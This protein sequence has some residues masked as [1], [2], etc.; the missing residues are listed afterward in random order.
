MAIDTN[1]IH[2]EEFIKENRVDGVTTSITIKLVAYDLDDLVEFTGD[3]TYLSHDDNT[4]EN[5]TI[6]GKIYWDFDASTALT[7]TSMNYTLP[8]DK[9]TTLTQTN[10]PMSVEFKAE[11]D[12][13]GEWFDLFWATEE[14]S[15]IRTQLGT[16]LSNL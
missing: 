7:S 16:A 11:R 3:G 13:R 4:W 14:Y 2:V 10:T 8:V 12:I 6:V 9:R 15:T 1:N 5:K